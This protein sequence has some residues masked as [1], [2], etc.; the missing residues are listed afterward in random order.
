M[1]PN[2]TT[3]TILS[4][5]LEISKVKSEISCGEVE[6]RVITIIEL[7]FESM[8][9]PTRKSLILGPASI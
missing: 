8:A 5:L 3:L 2:Q 9:F 1:K 7:Q 4:V 6:M